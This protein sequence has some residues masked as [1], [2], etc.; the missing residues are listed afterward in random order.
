MTLHVVGLLMYVYF[1]PLELSSPT[2][3]VWPVAKY[4]RPAIY[5]NRALPLL[6]VGMKVI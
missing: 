1:S 2:I 5:N 6:G 3:L 4:R